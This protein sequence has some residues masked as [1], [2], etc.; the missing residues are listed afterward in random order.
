MNT[1][2]GYGS[3]SDSDADAP[4]A[5]PPAPAALDADG[6]PRRRVI[7]GTCCSPHADG[8]PRR[9]R[10]GS[11]SRGEA[12]RRARRRLGGRPAVGLG[13]LGGGGTAS[14]L[15]K[16]AWAAAPRG[17]DRSRRGR[18]GGRA[19]AA[20]AA[21]A[22][23]G[24]RRAGTATTCTT[25]RPRPR[26]WESSRRTSSTATCAATG[27]LAAAGRPPP[28]QRAPPPPPPPKP[29]ASAERRPR[30]ADGPG[31]VAQRANGQSGIGRGFG[32]G[33]RRRETRACGNVAFS[34]P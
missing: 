30:T 3:S 18:P 2:A 29:A 5:A 24:P 15:D 33:G 21:V 10:W 34:A 31:R 23:R 9:R 14:W 6:A 17:P 16:P 26:L 32:C 19:R 11:R 20:A 25:L 12:G 4:A 7:P 27:S 28:Q 13:L 1:L 8:A 22:A